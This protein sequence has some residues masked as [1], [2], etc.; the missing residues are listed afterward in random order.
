MPRGDLLASAVADKALLLDRAGQRAHLLNASA[1][2]VWDLIDGARTAADITAIIAADA[3]LD[4]GTIA[5]DVEAAIDQFAA[6][7]LLTTDLPAA[8][9]PSGSGTAEATRANAATTAI[10]AS[11]IDDG[12]GLLSCGP[13]N[14]I[15]LGFVVRTDRAEVAAAVA[16]LLAE[17]AADA[18]ASTR[19]VITSTDVSDDGSVRYDVHV[20]GALLAGSRPLTAMLETMLVDANRRA[21]DQA[22]DRLVFHAGAID[23][24]GVVI[25]PAASGSGKST[26]TAALVARGGRYVSDEATVVH[27]ATLL[28]EPYPKP[29]SLSASSLAALAASGTTIV[30]PAPSGDQAVA[31]KRHIPVTDVGVA[32]AQL[33]PLAA[34]VFPTYDEDGPTSLEPLSPEDALVALVP[35]TF[36]ATWE[37]ADALERVVAMVESVPAF[38]L[39][40]ADLAEA[41]ALVHQTLPLAEAAT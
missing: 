18:V 15:G 35:C 1:A 36:A 26:L 8:D 7:G 32:A 16:P 5:G 23:L 14:A 40:F 17:L 21:I 37:V 30:D 29:L 12:N 6:A 10:A 34:I 3:D 22:R 20:D 13:Y 33:A 4:A 41:V 24:G 39:V 25:L 19:Y 2:W 38:R 31:A 9:P 27:P 11:A 28:V